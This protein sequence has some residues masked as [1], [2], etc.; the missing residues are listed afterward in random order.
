MNLQEGVR[1][2]VTSLMPGIRHAGLRYSNHEQ[3]RLKMM[4]LKRSLIVAAAA[5]TLGMAG[6]QA[7][8]ADWYGHDHDGYGDRGDWHDHDDHDWHGGGYY[9]GPPPVYYAPPPA[10]YAPPP[11]YYAPPPVY[12]A[13]P[14]ITFGFRP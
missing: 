4:N 7:A 9:Y 14:V 10:Y 6:T 1:H 5:L 2:N 8:K 12:Y 3:W 11:R 13:P